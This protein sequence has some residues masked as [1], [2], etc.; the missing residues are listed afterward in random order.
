MARGVTTTAGRRDSTTG[1]GVR[2]MVAVVVAPWGAWCA[3]H[4][5][6]SWQYHG[7]WCAPYGGR[8]SVTVGRV[9][10]A[11]RQAVVAAPQGVVRAPWWRYHAWTVVSPPHHAYHTMHHT[12]PQQYHAFT[13]SSF[14]DARTM[15]KPHFLHWAFGVVRVGPVGQVGQVPQ[16]WVNLVYSH[17]HLF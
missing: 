12:T 1:H 4:G 3:H 7:A 8:G 17:A 15:V 2:P 11:P 9:G 10:R 16:E 5:R 13:T 6:P 14:Y